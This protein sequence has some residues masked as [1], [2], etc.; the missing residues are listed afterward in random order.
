MNGHEWIDRRS[1]AFDAIVAE[2]V[3]RDPKL[4]QKAIGNLERWI[5][6]RQPDPP[7]VL[8]EWLDILQS[9]DVSKILTLLRASDQNATRLRQSSPFCG[10]LTEEER[11][12]ILK[13]Y[14]ATRA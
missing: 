1:L 11:L 8:F 3:E 10:I 14:E 7:Q 6:Q 5:S 2:K 13:E 9:S 4:I 12:A